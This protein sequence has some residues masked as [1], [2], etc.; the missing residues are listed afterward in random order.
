MDNNIRLST[1]LAHIV[2]R[3]F[4]W[5]QAADACKQSGGGW[6]VDLLFWWHLVFPDLVIERA[7]LPNNKSGLLISINVLEMVC[8]IVNMAAAIFVCDH[9]DIDLATCPMLLNY[10]DNTAAC[11]WVNDNCKH[12]LIGRRLGRIFVGLI[13]GTKIG[14]QCEWILTYLNYI[15]DDISRLKELDEH[16]EFDYAELKKTYPI[17]EPCRKFKP[18]DTLLTMIWDVLLKESCPD[19]LMIKDLKPSALGQFIS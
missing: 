7:C 9:D 4:K 5:V 13:M 19:P 16:G 3:D 6:S 14:I 8:V 15:A 18:S 10:C 12:S 17:L 1:P 2:R 11:T